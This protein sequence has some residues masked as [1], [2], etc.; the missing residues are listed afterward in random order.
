M[1]KVDKSEQ[2]RVFLGLELHTWG[3]QVFPFCFDPNDSGHEQME[4]I[5]FFR[6]KKVADPKTL[7]KPVLRDVQQS[8]VCIE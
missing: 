1:F 4:I 7:R 6:E 3:S 8:S 2:E 5:F